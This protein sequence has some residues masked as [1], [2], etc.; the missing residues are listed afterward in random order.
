MDVI[1]KQLMW[2]FSSHCGYGA[3]RVLVSGIWVKLNLNGSNTEEHLWSFL[4]EFQW[5]IACIAWTSWAARGEHLLVKI[6]KFR[7][8]VCVCVWILEF[9]ESSNILGSS[10]IEAR[11]NL[12]RKGS[13]IA[14]IILPGIDTHAKSK[15]G[16]MLDF[17][18][19]GTDVTL[20]LQHCTRWSEFSEILET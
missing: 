5:I 17:P 9:L 11:S 19:R 6:W 8:C 13:L 3:R 10:W 14:G 4:N 1:I 2:Y 7:V 12:C 20:K 18:E 15:V 16:S